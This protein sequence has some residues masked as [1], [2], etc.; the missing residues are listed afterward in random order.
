MAR[1]VK[2]NEIILYHQLLKTSNQL[3]IILEPTEESPNDPPSP[4]IPSYAKPF[5]SIE[6]PATGR[7]VPFDDWDDDSLSPLPET[8]ESTPTPANNRMIQKLK[9]NMNWSGLASKSQTRGGGKSDSKIS[10]AMMVQPGPKTNKI[11]LNADDSEQWKEAISKEMA[12]MESY[13]VFTF[14]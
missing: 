7:I 6:L 8:Q 10:I 14:V 5:K 11:A 4:I 2:F 3:R 1:D 9:S 12:S 13:G